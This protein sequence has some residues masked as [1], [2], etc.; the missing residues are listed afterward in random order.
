MKQSAIVR[1]LAVPAHW[2]DAFL[3]PILPDSN[4]PEWQDACARPIP[5]VGK[6]RTGVADRARSLG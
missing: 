6:G 5:R 2:P 4:A 3:G 1:A